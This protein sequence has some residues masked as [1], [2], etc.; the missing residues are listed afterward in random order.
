MGVAA[1]PECHRPPQPTI[2]EHGPSTSGLTCWTLPGARHRHIPRPFHAQAG[3]AGNRSL[4]EQSHIYCMMR[5]LLTG[6]WTYGLDLVWLCRLCT[7]GCLLWLLHVSTSRR[8][9]CCRAR[10]CITRTGCFGVRS[11]TS[12]FQ[13]EGPLE[14]LHA[15]RSSQPDCSDWNWPVRASP[16]IKV[17]GASRTEYSFRQT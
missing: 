11:R 13:H 15:R 8:C 4:L 9:R 2:P 3:T 1:R 7:G 10:H 12:V 14:Q 6:R 16:T 17:P 5:T